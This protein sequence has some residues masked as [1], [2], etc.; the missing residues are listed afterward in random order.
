MHRSDASAVRLK[1]TGDNNMFMVNYEGVRQFTEGMLVWVSECL[2]RT[3]G[4]FSTISITL[5]PGKQK[6]TAAFFRSP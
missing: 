6:V 5:A 4:I 2:A 3:L 1:R